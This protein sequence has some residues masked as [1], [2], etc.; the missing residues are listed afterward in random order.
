M[1]MQVYAEARG[2]HQSCCS[3]V[4][5]LF[6]LKQILSLNLEVRRWP[7]RLRDP[8][9]FASNYA[10]IIGIVMPCIFV[11][12]LGD[13]NSGPH[14]YAASAH[15]SSHLTPFKASKISGKNYIQLSTV[16]C[17][18]VLVTWESPE[19][20]LCLQAQGYPGHHSES[21]GVAPN[22]IVSIF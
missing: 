3:T 5:C 4:V 7:A 6:L 10:A 1:Y 19:N 17:I 8:P 16:A 9:I 22:L 11:W 20:H 21:Q 15:L 13:L 14:V 18:L 2:K 12:V